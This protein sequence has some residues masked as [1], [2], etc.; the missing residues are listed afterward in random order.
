MKDDLAPVPPSAPAPL[1][2]PAP[3]SPPYAP[4]FGYQPPYPY[5]Q[6]YAPVPY[7][8]PQP[9]PFRTAVGFELGR[10]AA[11]ALVAV[12]IGGTTVACVLF[13]GWL[14]Y[15]WYKQRMTKG[16][17][18]AAREAGRAVQVRVVEKTPVADGELP[19]LQGKL[20]SA[21]DAAAPATKVKTKVRAR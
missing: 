9:S 8:P 13:V 2:P 10:R 19:A 12:A 11:G 16:Q 14:G 21:V 1:V 18:A 3:Y 20:T 17:D 6:P 7:V 15:R 4:P 5:A